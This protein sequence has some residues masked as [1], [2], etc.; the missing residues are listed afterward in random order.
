MNKLKS[1]IRS[2]RLRTL[3][4]SVSGII[5]GTLLAK[6]EGKYNNGVF[7]LALSTTLC[8]QILSN[9]ANELGDTLKGTDN[10]NRLGPT[11]SIQAGLLTLNDFKHL[12]ILFILL[13]LLSGISL[14]LLSFHNLFTYKSLLLLLSG[15]AAILAAIKYTIGK[16]PYG[17]RG[18]GD[19]FVFLFFGLL[20]T[21]GAYF[22]LVH[23]LSPQLLL[24]ASSLG[25]LCTAVLNVNNIRD[26]END[27]ICGKYTLPVKIGE[28]NARIYHTCLIAGALSGYLIYTGISYNGISSFLPLLTLPLFLIHLHAVWTNSGKK[29]DAQLK[30]LSLTTLAFSILWGIGQN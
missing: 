1:C 20:S 4:L 3:P 12:I 19:L 24:P 27:R 8:L 7:L 21:L 5:L 22:L 18:L 9:L 10:D 6:S 23:T 16:N 17:Y 14:V 29:L 28:K 30:F 13:S 15:G 26:M 2:F 11:R 25:L